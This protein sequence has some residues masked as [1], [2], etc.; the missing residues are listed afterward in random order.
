MSVDEPKLFNLQNQRP[1]QSIHIVSRSVLDLIGNT[2][3]LSLSKL[4]PKREVKILGKAEWFNPGGS[5]KDRPVLKIISEAEKRGLLRGKTILDATSGNAGISYAMIGASKGYPVHLCVPANVSEVT[6]RIMLAFGA[7]LTATSA[8]QGSD[9]AILKARELYQSNPERYF[10]GDQYSNE[11]NWKAHNITTGAEIIEQTEGALTHFVAGTGTSGTLMGVG[12][13]LRKRNPKIRLVEVQPSS[14]VHGIDGLKHMESS[15]IPS[16]Y[17]PDFADE[18][19]VVETEE[20]QDLVRRVAREE[21]ILLGTSSGANLVA[22]LRIAEKLSEGK[23]VTVLPD[24]AVRYLSESYWNDDMKTDLPG[25]SSLGSTLIN[26]G[27][28]RHL[29]WRPRG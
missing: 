17:D 12:R 24:S 23:V 4:S 22:A 1:H 21:G 19:M 5:I 16:I 20:A 15:I 13:R 9:G 18:K 25:K 11:A 2:P 28:S 3:L 8:L 27:L 7:R 26:A 14:P 29:I 10:Y 6:K